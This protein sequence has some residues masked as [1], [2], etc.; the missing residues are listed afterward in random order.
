MTISSSF[1]VAA[2]ILYSVAVW[3]ERSIK[4]LLT[5]IIL[6]FILGFV[7]D[8]IGTSFMFQTAGTIK[9]GIHSGLG[10]LALGIMFF[11]LLL[12]ILSKMKIRKCEEY[13]TRFSIIAWSVWIAAFL[14]GAILGIIAK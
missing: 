7:C 8:A 2:L 5:W 12:A 13:F 11:H 1:M 4:K 10:Y 14:T 3:T 6:V 9:L